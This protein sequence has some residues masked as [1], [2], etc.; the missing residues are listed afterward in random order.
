MHRRHFI[1]NTT[2]SAF[3]VSAFGFIRF[4]GDHY[5]GDCETTTDILGP[6]YRPDSPVRNNL[7]I[8]G[9][10][11]ELVE[12]TG[13]IKHKDCVTPYKNAKIELWHCDNK[14]VYDNETQ[15]YR[16]RGT[17]YCDD[18]GQY[19][20]H[21]MLPVAYE[22]GVGFIRPAHFHM[23][24]TAEGYQPLI[25]QLYFTGDK[26][27]P[28]DSSAASPLAKKRILDVQTKPDGTKKVQYDVSMSEQ[29]A[30]NPSEI[31]KLTGM[32][33]S[34]TDKTKTMEFANRN[35]ILWMKNE[36]YGR[37]F[38]YTG[39]NSFEYPGVPPGM[40]ERLSFLLISGGGV[41]L[42]YSYM[43]DDSVP[44]SSVYLKS[45]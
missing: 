19:S 20:F 17:S 37:D 6:F 40:Y 28:K 5:V 22:T 13:M 3:A 9:A 32:Y 39:N 10:P 1:K 38:A 4:D 44:H 8:P 21:T 16:Y 30:A 27:I 43:D 12:L 26:Y 36:V 31:D 45:K 24:I 23:M 18:K 34:E 11:G 41:K 42:T 29:L 15:E 2:F 14:G 35:N 33:T 25:T 7:V